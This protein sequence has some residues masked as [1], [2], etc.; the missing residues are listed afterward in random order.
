M[1]GHVIFAVWKRNVSSF[2]SGVLGYLFMVVFV[3]AAAILA[4]NDEF[5][6]NNLANLD[7][8]NDK[9][10]MLLL[11]IVPAI[12]MSAW[13]D[14]RKM[15]TD[16]LLFTLPATD[17]EILLAKYLS[18]L[19]VYTVALMFSVCQL[20][21]LAWYADPEWG[22]LITTY[23]G[24][25]LAGAALLSVGMFASALTNSTTVAFVLGVVI[26]SVPVFVGDLSSGNQLLRSLSLDEQFRE[27]ALGTVPLVGVMYFVSLTAFMLYLNLVV[28]SKRHWSG[29]QQANMGLQF[30]ARTLSLAAILISVNFMARASGGLF[31]LQVDLTSENLYSLSD[32]TKETI[33][34]VDAD[35]LVTIHAF[36]SDEMPPE[37]VEQRNRLLGLLRQYDRRGGPRVV[38][39][40]VDGVMR[41]SEKAE[42]AEMF[43]VMPRKVQTEV[44]GRMRVD[45]VFLGLVVSGPY[46]EV[47]VPFVE[48]K[49][50]IEYELTRSIRTVTVRRRK[51]IG[52]LRTDAQV[53]GG[54]EPGSFRNLPEWQ[55]IR[56]L[57]KQYHVETASADAEILHSR[58]TVDGKL[59]LAGELQA[60]P[61][62]KKLKER[63]IDQEINLTDAARLVEDGQQ[64]I[65]EDGDAR[66]FIKA[67]DN[68]SLNVTSPFDVLLAILP[69]SLTQPQMGN[70]V[71]YVKS[72][73]PVLIFDDPAPVT[74][75]MQLAPRQ[76]KR[77]PQGGGM[78]GGGPPPEQKAD[79][80]KATSLLDV[81]EVAW[82]Y[83]VVVWDS[84]MPHPNL[85]QLT[86]EELVW[87]SPSSGRKSAFSQKSAVTS[88]L[89]ELLAF[90]PGHIQH[91]KGGVN[92]WEDLLTTTEGSGIVRWEDLVQ[93]T[94]MGAGL[95]PKEAVAAGRQLEKV[96]HSLAAHITSDE[97]DGLNVIYVADIDC[98]SDQAFDIV[99][100]EVLNLK[101]D[102][103][104]FGLN[105]VDLL[106]DDTRYINLRKRR[107]EHRTLVEI[108]KQ[109][110]SF[111]R[112][113]QEEVE[114]AEEDAKEQ[115]TK[116]KENLAERQKEI[117]G[118][119]GLTAR[120]K[121]VQLRT[122]QQD[123][124]RK[125]VVAEEE[126]NQ[127]KEDAIER[128][129][130]E[131]QREILG[132]ER[133]IKI[134][135]ILIPPLP[136][137]F[138]GLLVLAIRSNSD[139]ENMDRNRSRSA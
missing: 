35:T 116:A 29:D 138:L 6:S 32:T 33:D 60:G 111:R 126:I 109:T 110:D 15:G 121:E 50:P 124:Q 46:D 123:Q 118:D 52:V 108:Q 139:R 48:A 12:T 19:S 133:T 96:P 14:E 17:L 21:V 70:L 67:E 73:Y 80:G 54:F 103:V 5:F 105:A 23:F 90:F 9:F 39:R 120:E 62:S 76:Q 94:F 47:V 79:G 26:C 99:R 88:G 95:K 135:A 137:L 16:E 112:K 49:M 117:E 11:F 89:Q 122:A 28:I 45:D 7:Q 44:G 98:I 20:G 85:E 93:E 58:F 30:A 1:R 66:F 3:A 27:F 78:F 132:L 125:L 131:A 43:G 56:E 68:G 71:K 91:R 72:G 100:T 87:I 22:L 82:E 75:G 104:T 114:K 84:F 65:V 57:K 136:A 129:K 102:N 53:T 8:L 64:W 25:W 18:V 128:A 113:S 69:S 55:F 40:F 42:E 134:W 130:G 106:A 51:T 81:L 2:F 24:Y 86:Q 34:A 31:N 38:V 59:K 115:L 83:D 10:S 119:E 127:E 101:L 74:I 63:F 13:S 61:L 92:D 37:L 77:R 36:L 41:Y 107:G 4:F 97:N